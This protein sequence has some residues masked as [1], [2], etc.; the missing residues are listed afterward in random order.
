[1]LRIR[2]VTQTTMSLE[3]DPLEIANADL[4]SLDILRDGQRIAKIP[5]PLT[6]LS[7]KLS[8]LSMETDYKIQLVMYTSS[9]TFVSDEVHAKTHSIRDLSGINAC[10]GTIPDARLLE[11]TKEVLEA[12][13]AHYTTKITID[14]THLLC[15]SVP[16]PENEEQARI[17]SKA[18]Q[19]TLPIVQ[20]H[21]VF[22]CQE[23][24]R[25]VP[26]HFLHAACLTS[27]RTI[28]TR[29]RPTRLR[30]RSGSAAAARRNHPE[31]CL[32]L[33]HI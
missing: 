1:M 2:N 18:E 25:Y 31:K 3:W 32:S 7:T 8:G 4:H 30:S 12:V 10:L 5:H 9:G 26:R 23:A 16:T 27:R 28:W 24:G 15:A 20:P 17:Y 19:L 13:G 14:T 11:A 21:W 22:A 6:N 29:Y 33:I